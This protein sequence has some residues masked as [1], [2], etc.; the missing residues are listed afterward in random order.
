MNPLGLAPER[1]WVRETWA[2]NQIQMSDTHMDRSL[3]YRADGEERA[4]DN[5]VP[6]PWIPPVRMPR[7]VSRITL[8]IDKSWVDTAETPEGP[9]T[10]TW[11]VSVWRVKP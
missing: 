5:G 1:L 2:Q 4:E 8:E 9:W 10:W 11:G 3:V 6:R 7:C